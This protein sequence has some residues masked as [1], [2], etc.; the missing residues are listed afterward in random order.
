[1]RILINA[2]WVFGIGWAIFTGTLYVLAS[3]L[4]LNQVLDL[5]FILTNLALWSSAG[6]VMAVALG[7]RQPNRFKQ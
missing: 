3:V 2:D 1:M 7:L 4:V 6:I 5:E